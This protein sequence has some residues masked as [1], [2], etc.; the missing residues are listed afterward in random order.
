VRKRIHALG[1]ARGIGLRGFLCDP[2]LTSEYGA[3][4]FLKCIDA[5][6]TW[7]PKTN[8]KVN[9]LRFLNRGKS[10]EFFVLEGVY[11]VERKN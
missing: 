3:R 1:C 10:R 5:P 11:R 7:D 6:G 4:V 9:V 8:E 2:S